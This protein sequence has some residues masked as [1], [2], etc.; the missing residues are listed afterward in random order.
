MPFELGLGALLG[1]GAGHP[2]R[3]EHR[4]GRVGRV[5]LRLGVRGP[6]DAQQLLAAAT[7]LRVEQP[8]GPV[9]AAAGHASERLR[10]RLG[11]PRRALGEHGADHPLRDAAEGDEL[12]AGANR[13]RQ[14]AELVGHEH[15]HGVRRRLLEIL[16]QRVGGVLVQQVRVGDHVDAPLGLVRAHVQV[17][18]Q[19]SHLVDPDHLAERLEQEEVGVRPGLHAALVAEQCGRERA[20]RR[21]LADPGR[22]VEEIG[23][24]RPFRHGGREQQPRLGLLSQA[25]ERH[26]GSS[27]R[28][29]RVRGRRRA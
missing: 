15:D 16:Q 10:L 8:L 14:R 20:G 18:V 17:A 24:G 22:P 7:S 6:G 3:L 1:G 9:E 2:R 11:Q 21:P 25:G 27:P 5:E 13:R 19:R 12:A 29:R 23:V 28:A 26:S 4:R